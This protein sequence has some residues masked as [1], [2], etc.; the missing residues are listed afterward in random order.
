M[1][2]TDSILI[3]LQ[4]QNRR[5]KQILFIGS[6]AGA[7]LV[8]LAAKSVIQTQKFTEIDVER[9]NIVMPDGKR[10]MVLSNHLRAPAPMHD[11]KEIVRSGPARPGI[12]FYDSLGNENGGLIFDGKLDEKGKPSAGMHFSMD[13]FGGDQQLALFKYEEQGTMEAGL[14]VFDRGAKNDYQPIQDKMEKLPEGPEKDELRKQWIA[15]GGPQ[16]TRTFVGKTR[17]RS[18]AVILADTKGK[19]RIMMLVSPEGE[20]SLEFMD[21]QGKVIQRLPDVAPKKL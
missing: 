7:S 18:A 15:A 17:G 12:F 4:K 14:K 6:L 16:T 20:P 9:I 13:R 8:T 3:E 2:M 19:A 21:E 11:G 1:D 10:E 5:L